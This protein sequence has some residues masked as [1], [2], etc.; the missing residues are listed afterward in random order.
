[1]K[2]NASMPE[3]SI[4]F[5]FVTPPECA[6]QIVEVAYALAADADLII[7]RRFDHSDRTTTYYAYDGGLGEDWF[8]PHNRAP[9]LGR[10]IGRCTVID[11]GG[12]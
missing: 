9:E 10:C 12:D 8:E 1:M 4:V 5:D 3:F 11:Q 7:E 6:G 2:G